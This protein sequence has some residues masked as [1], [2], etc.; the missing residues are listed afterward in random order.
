MNDVARVLEMPFGDDH[1]DL[2][3]DEFQNDM[4]NSLLMLIREEAD[5][6]PC[7]SQSCKKD[8]DSTKAGLTGRRLRSFVL[9]HEDVSEQ[10]SSLQEAKSGDPCDVSCRPVLQPPPAPVQA[11]APAPAAPAAAFN[12]ATLEEALRRTTEDLSQHFID[13]KANTKRLSDQLRQTTEVM[14]QLSLA[15]RSELSTEA[16]EHAK[17]AET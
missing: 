5:I 1:N 11:C 13:L 14:L 9:S 12:Y 4:S 16:L 15:T 7:T 8:F 10:K 2:P 6:V 17:G 3:L